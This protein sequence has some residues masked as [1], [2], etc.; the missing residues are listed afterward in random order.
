MVKLN[1]INWHDSPISSLNFDFNKGLLLMKFQEFGTLIHYQ[2]LATHVLI[3]KINLEKGLE[4]S[5][6]EISDLKSLQINDDLYE[7]ALQVYSPMNG[8]V[9]LK[10]ECSD[11]NITEVK[12]FS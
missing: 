8:V 10:F 6:C 12:L 11:I 2:L 1:A 4:V 9:K 3:K 5:N 7:I